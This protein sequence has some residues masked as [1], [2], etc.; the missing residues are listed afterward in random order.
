MLTKKPLYA[1]G[2][3]E[4][5]ILFLIAFL[6]I[7]IDSMSQF[8]IHTHLYEVVGTYCGLTVRTLFRGAMKD[9]SFLLGYFQ[10]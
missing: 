4:R 10:I 2:V 7:N 9:L 1:K 6:K 3:S 8:E 5:L